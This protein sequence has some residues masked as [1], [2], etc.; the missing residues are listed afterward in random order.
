M[1]SNTHP[2]EIV[3]R[4]GMHGIDTCSITGPT[5][6]QVLSFARG[7]A[8]GVF[9]FRAHTHTSESSE[10]SRGGRRQRGRDRA[11]SNTDKPGDMQ[12]DLCAAF[13]KFYP[14]V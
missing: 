10:T 3:I 11:D 6:Q 14:F 4:P 12:V 7:A 1:H 9:L 5:V 8:L 2:L 13:S